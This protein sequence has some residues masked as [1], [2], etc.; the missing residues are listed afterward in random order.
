MAGG[1]VV[2]DEGHGAH[3]FQDL[4]GGEDDHADEEG[5][6][7]R[8][9]SQHTES[10][11]KKDSRVED[12]ADVAPFVE[13]GCEEGGENHHE[14]GVGAAQHSEEPGPFGGE[15]E[16]GVEGDQERPLG[17]DEPVAEGGQGE[18]QQQGPG[19]KDGE[20]RVGGF[21]LQGRSLRSRRPASGVSGR[22]RIQR[23]EFRGGGGKGQGGRFCGSLG[24]GRG[25]PVQGFLHEEA[26]HPH[27]RQGGGRVDEE[28][29]LQVVPEEEP[30]NDLC[31]GES[32]VEPQVVQRVGPV[33]LVGFGE[34]R[35]DGVVG[36][37]GHAEAEGGKH[38]HVHHGQRRFQKDSDPVSQG[39]QGLEYYKNPLAAEAVGHLSSQQAGGGVDQPHHGDIAARF[40][41]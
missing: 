14:E 26:D 15:V 5:R 39:R 36:G 21:C 32:Q 23:D 4:S 29:V 34:I 22:C 10:Q 9:V 3:R 37:A 1:G 27:R 31:E 12:P 18:N 40:A 30:R 38:Q 6:L 25:V 19:L 7:E 35:R 17:V 11:G 41:S 2:H 8:D 20:D 13:Q 28:H 24:Q 16:L 33:P